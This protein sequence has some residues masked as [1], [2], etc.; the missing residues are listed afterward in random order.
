[1]VFVRKGGEARAV[2]VGPWTTAGTARYE[3]GAEIMW[4]K[5]GLGAFM[6]HMPVGRFPD[7]E[8]V[9]PDASSRSF[10]LKGSA[11]PFPNHENAETFVERLVRGGVL[12]RDPLI[13]AVLRGR[14][15]ELS[16]RTVR[17][18]F[19]R[20]TGLS[21]NRILQ[22]ERAQH[23]ATLLRQGGQISDAVHEAGYFDQSHLTR[24]LKQWVGRTP[25]QIL[26]S[27]GAA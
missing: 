13:E 24:S 2:F 9:L 1:M 7:T 11:W 17:H 4:I 19:S 15:Q 10:W 16:P 22:I 8:T 18:R 20:A 14:P 26:R 25:A 3:E 23:A 12:A 21:Q 6:P 27:S 5:F